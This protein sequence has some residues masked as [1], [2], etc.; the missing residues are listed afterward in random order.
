MTTA[1]PPESLLVSHIR[2][3]VKQG[4]KARERAD[5]AREKA[6]Q[7]FI[8]AG[9]Y[10]V[11]LKVH[12]A[13]D[14]AAWELL[15][16]TKVDISTGR[17]SELMQL[18]DGRKDLQQIRDATAQRVKALRASRSSSLQGRC[19]EHDTLISTDNISTHNIRPHNIG[20]HNIPSSGSKNGGA[21]QLIDALVAS[22]SNSREAAANLVISGPRQS[23][24][25]TT[26]KAVADFYV[27]LSRAGR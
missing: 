24:F 2:A 23:Q 14:W 11:M 20:T 25:T 15:L 27:L 12:Y 21:H 1:P 16:K 26:V 18:A 7:H 19:N 10:L 3:H 8:A 5:Q 17:A 6:E 13:A 9:R 22:S 4:E